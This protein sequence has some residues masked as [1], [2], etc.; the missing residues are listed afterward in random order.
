MGKIV[1][2][3]DVSEALLALGP[4]NDKAI[5]ASKLAA[6]SS[7]DEHEIALLSARLLS[8]VAARISDALYPDNSGQ[9]YIAAPQ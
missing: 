3:L 6:I 2:E 1:I 9:E 5:E 8:R 4:I 7:G